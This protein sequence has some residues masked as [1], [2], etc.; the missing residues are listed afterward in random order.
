VFSAFLRSLRTKTSRNSLLTRTE[1]R[2]ELARERIRATRRSFP[3]CVLEIKL[4]PSVKGPDARRCRKQIAQTLHR[5]VR[6]T[7]HKAELSANEFAILFTDTPEMGGRSAMARLETLFESKKVPVE[8]RLDVFD[9]DAFSNDDDSDSADSGTD[10]QSLSNRRSTDKQFDRQW[11]EVTGGVGLGDD[12]TTTRISAFGQALKRGVDIVGATFGLIVTGP[13]ILAAMA[14]IRWTDGQSAIFKQ[15]REGYRGRPFTIYKLRTMIVNAEAQQEALRE[16]SHRDGPAFKIAD[17]PRVTRVG[18]FLRKT[19]L[20]E[21]PQLWN[22]LKGEMSLVGPRP[23]PWH[24]S[25]A[26]E[27]WHRRR[28]DVRPGMTCY[29]QVQKHNIESFDD[30]MRL[31]LK[32]VEQLGLFEDLRL[33]MKTIAVPVFGRGGH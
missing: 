8:M 23:L 28:L 10:S 4:K 29:W 32:Y 25:R 18:N 17:D 20:D 2:R 19:C 24:E 13:V 3:Y 30:W 26:C 5:N 14:A 9:R 16:Q 21:L 1:F 6:L 27:N 22:V 15:T 33:I 12:V 7:D 11:R 31:D